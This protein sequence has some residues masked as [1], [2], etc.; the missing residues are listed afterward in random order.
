M[1]ESTSA[2]WVHEGLRQGF[3]TVFIRKT[4]R[5]WRFSGHVAALEDGVAWSV[6]YAIA[7][8]SAWR[9]RSARVRTWDARGSSH[10]VLRHDGS[11]AWT[12]D[13]RPAAFLE[14]CLDVDLEASACTNTFPVHR[15]SGAP[16]AVETPAAYVR[17]RDS[18]V[19]RLDQVYARETAHA[20]GSRWSYRAP[21]FD[22][23]C[24]LEYD[25]QALVVTYPGI[26]RRVL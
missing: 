22:F 26:A 6:R 2:A 16:G 10:V 11:G 21:Q 13:G 20:D 18:A 23:A 12:I 3:E 25:D 19:D 8:D 4:T 7:V 15:L 5:G 24:T 14:G 1:R 9:T 17:V